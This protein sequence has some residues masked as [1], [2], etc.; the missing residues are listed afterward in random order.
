MSDNGKNETGQLLKILESMGMEPSRAVELLKRHHTPDLG[1]AKV[2]S[3]RGWSAALPE[4]VLAPGKTVEEVVRITEKL[5][6]DSAL[7]MVSRLS[8]EQS[9]ALQDR[10]PGG[11]YHPRPS[12]FT[13]GE[14]T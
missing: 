7:A 5:L 4:V 13:S 3:G 12:F 6:K 10:I 8:E 14:Y 1:Y 11:K 9:K 2:D